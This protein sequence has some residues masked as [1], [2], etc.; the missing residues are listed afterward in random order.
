MQIYLYQNEQQ[1]GPFTVEDI[2]NMIWEG[3]VDSNDLGWHEGLTE[4]QPLNSFLP[5][6][7][8]LP[9]PAKPV[10][11]SPTYTENREASPARSRQGWQQQEVQTNVKQGAIIGG[12]VCFLLGVLTMYLSMWTFVIYGPLFLV[13]FI[14]S[15]VAMSQRRVLGGIALLLATLVVP[16]ILGLFLFS[17]RTVEFAEKMSNQIEP[18]RKPEG[19]PSVQQQRAILQRK[20]MDI[21]MMA[22]NAIAEGYDTSGWTDS[23]AVI[24]DLVKG[25][26]VEK[27]GKKLG[28]FKV[29]GLSPET[30]AALN[31]S[32]YLKVSYGLPMYDQNGTAS[33]P[34]TSPSNATAQS[35]IRV[36]TIA[37][38]TPRPSKY[39]ALD[40]KNGF[41]KYRLGSP[42]SE[43][44]IF[45]FEPCRDAD[46]DKKTYYPKEFDK[47]IGSAEID[48]I[49]LEFCQDI[50]ENITL[51]VKGDQNEIA[52]KEAFISAYG[53]PT[54]EWQML[55]WKG[56][57]TQLH[58]VQC[59]GSTAATFSNKDVTAKINQLRHEK[60]KEGAV[61]AAK[62][63]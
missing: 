13:A 63:L 6:P 58:M 59:I 11:A 42:L 62:D 34:I 32:G 41:R 36:E 19:Q 30:I 9:A 23:N 28:P 15:I 61:D 2:R 24:S 45:S 57:K 40:E 3:S 47:K 22:G 54:T 43:F 51:T 12:W 20:A 44:D 29:N 48:H 38:A 56:A 39:P 18:E 26:T 14:L 52:L 27:N 31:S 10:S 21:A 55:V 37:A 49:S 46:S 1:V 16:A 8:N 35:S 33:E 53:E 60:A 4:W 5:A 7:Q 25:V 17:T 50:L